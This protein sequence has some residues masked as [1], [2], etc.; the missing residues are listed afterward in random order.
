L[1][2]QIHRLG[3]T[4]ESF[5]RL[6]TEELER[7]VA[8]DRGA[9]RLL[10]QTAFLAA[11]FDGYRARVLDS[12]AVDEPALRRRLL[13]EPGAPPLAHVIVS[14]G[15]RVAEPDGLWPADFDLLT[16]LEGVR[17]I[18]VVATEATLAVG[19]IE[20]LRAALPGMDEVS[21]DPARASR[22]TLEVPRPSGAA[23]RPELLFVSRDREEELAAIARRLKH[24]AAK[25]A[26]PALDRVAIVVRRPLPYLYLARETFGSAGIPFETLDTLPLAAEPYAAAVDI[27]LNAVIADFSRRALI[28]LLRTPHF[29]YDPVDPSAWRTSIADLDRA[30]AEARYQGGLERLDMLHRE[31]SSIDTPKRREERRRKNALPAMGVALAV[32]ERLSALTASSRVVE[33]IDAVLAFLRAYDGS[34]D[35]GPEGPPLSTDGAESGAKAPPLRTVAPAPPSAAHN[36]PLL[37]DPATSARHQRVRAAV[38]GAIN[39]LGAAYRRH[40][41]AAEG[42]VMALASA[43]RRWLGARTFA[44][45]TGSP[46]VQIVDAQAVRY[47]VFDSVYLV[48]VIHGE[49][50]EPTMRTVLYPASM[51]ALLDPSPPTPRETI[52]REREAAQAARAAFRDLL[53]LAQRRVRV[54]TFLLEHDAIVEPSTLVD[55]MAAM[56]LPAEPIDTVPTARIFLHE[57]MTKHPAALWALPPLASR[58]AHA[59]LEPREEA[60][61]FH[62]AAGPWILPRVSVSRLERYLDCPFRFFSSEVLRLDEQPEDE[63][64]RTPLERGRF[65]HELFEAFFSE[66]Q[67]RGH[68]RVTPTTLASAR[69]LFEELCEDALSALPPAEAA[70]ERAR[71]LGS[72][73]SAGIAHRVLAMEAERTVEVTERLLEFPLQGDFTFRGADDRTQTVTLSAIADRIDLL[74]DGTMRVIDY[75]SKLTP[76]VKQALQLPIYSLC[77]RDRLA[78]HQGRAWQLGEALYLSFEGQRAVVPLRVRGTTLDELID[79]AEERLLTTLDDIAAGTFP[80]RPARKSLCSVCPYSAVCRLDW[81]EPAGG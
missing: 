41:P 81:V 18:D 12:G 74:A 5:H 79:A 16:R 73:V 80:P 4:L 31:W 76:D 9:E 26:A 51:M 68:G 61:R 50:P 7:G 42:D 63:D 53:M 32:A 23:G 66:W 69:A 30:L 56:S 52:R 28:A 19:L 47:G 17:T 62:G 2:D 54:S 6:F 71:L 59:R 27:A 20:R 77:S 8:S 40:D 25:T 57:A 44:L 38:V 37:S 11:T 1:Y 78:G 67:R 58:W 55:E 10:G 49:W 22:P 46:G 15:D 14:I 48:G 21:H 70:L 24:E 35:G 75:K 34:L 36:A 33:Q 65:L 45:R 29:G 60:A 13:D 43:V 72:A 64:T 39:A 3:R